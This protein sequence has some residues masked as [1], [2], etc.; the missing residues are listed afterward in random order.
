MKNIILTNSSL[1]F[2]LVGIAFIAHGADFWYPRHGFF[3]D[4]WDTQAHVPILGTYS[5]GRFGLPILRLHHP[6]RPTQLRQL[7]SLPAITNWAL[8]HNPKTAAAWDALEA[9]AA[10]LGIA[11]GLWLPTISGQ[12]QGQRSQTLYSKG[13]SAPPL[14]GFYSTL[15]LSE[16]LFNFGYRRA[17][18]AKAEAATLVKRLETDAAIQQVALNVATAYYRLAE[19]RSEVHIYR[20]AVREARQIE[21]DT[22]L[23]YRARLKPV[24]DVYQ[25]QNVLAQEEESLSSAEGAENSAR[26]ALAEAAGLPVESLVQALSLEVPR[27]ELPHP[28]QHWLRVGLLHNPSV[29]ADLA[30]MREARHA[31]AQSEAQGL[32]SISLVGNLGQDLF[33]KNP[34]E[35]SFSI[36]IQINIPFDS[37]F[38]TT[39]QVQEDRALYRESKASTQDTA[40]SILLKIWQSYAGLRSSYRA[41]SAVHQQTKSAQKA[42][43]GIHTEYRIGLA[44]IL[45]LTTAEENLVSAQIT[46]VQVLA[47]YYQDRAALFSYAGM[48]PQQ[49]FK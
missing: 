33:K 29:L 41:L 4:P 39:Y 36:G 45:D 31:I 17:S 47:Q 13:F 5:S 30:S 15:S 38:S 16:E 18:I 46:R 24:T 2:A 34:N 44:N 32:P 22:H 26:G 48:A 23:Q 12:V 25:A 20:N 9:Q 21:R 42:L 1:F 27:T 7:R 43:S 37:N 11:K 14:N 35:R 8:Q 3:A 6:P 19:A 10:A 28:I 40:Q 49:I